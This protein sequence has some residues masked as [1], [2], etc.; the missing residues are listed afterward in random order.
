MCSIG[1]PLVGAWMVLK[2]IPCVCTSMIP[3][4]MTCFKA[5]WSSQYFEMDGKR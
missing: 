4:S 5:A 2:R 1:V 3:L